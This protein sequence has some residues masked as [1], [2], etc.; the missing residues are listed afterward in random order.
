MFKGKRNAEMFA[1]LKSCTQSNSNAMSKPLIKMSY[2]CYELKCN[3]GLITLPEVSVFINFDTQLCMFTADKTGDIIKWCAIRCLIDVIMP[4]KVKPEVASYC[5]LTFVMK[6]NYV[7][8]S[9]LSEV[10]KTVS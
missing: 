5:I 10:D 1:L 8:D 6:T 3:A 9:F 4:Q 2:N 7:Q